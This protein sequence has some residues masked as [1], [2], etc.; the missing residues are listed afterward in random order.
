MFTLNTHNHSKRSLFR[1]AALALPFIAAV[2]SLNAAEIA[3]PAAKDALIT[4]SQAAILKQA[5]QIYRISVGGAQITAISDGT[6]PL[7]AP[8]LLKGKDIASMQKLLNKSF[9]NNDVETSINVYLI[10][11]DGHRILVD[12][13]AGEMISH[14]HIGG[15]LFESLKVAGVSP[16]E[17]TDILVTHIHK[18][19]TGGLVV[20][21]KRVFPNAVVHVGNPDVDFFLDPKQAATSSYRPKALSRAF[22]EAVQMVKPYKDAG[23]LHAFGNLTEILPGITATFHPG[24]TP[25]S[26]FYTLT[27]NGETIVFI[28]DTVHVEAVQFS[29]PEVTIVFDVNPKAAAANR[30]KAFAELSHTRVLVAAPH[31]LYPGIGHIRAE[32]KAY[33]WVPIPFNNR[34]E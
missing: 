16:E 20:G 33:A 22:E 19:H 1:V 28:G 18:D 31:L 12:T 29:A 9:L 15:R 2:A 21:D 5:P 6:I 30:A 26:A 8:T 32:G 11:M 24:H 3:K 25:G 4:T 7:N 13:G 34:V 27:R 10:E 23:R 14:E 17:I